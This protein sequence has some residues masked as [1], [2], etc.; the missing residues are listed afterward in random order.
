MEQ[1]VSIANNTLTLCIVPRIQDS[2]C[3]EI[4]E[5]KLKTWIVIYTLFEQNLIAVD[6]H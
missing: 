6:M 4:N 3:M 2:M 5:L 1:T